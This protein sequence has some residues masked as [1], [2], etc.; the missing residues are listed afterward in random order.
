LDLHA[1]NGEPALLVEEGDPFHKSGD[2]F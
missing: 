1:E 2:L